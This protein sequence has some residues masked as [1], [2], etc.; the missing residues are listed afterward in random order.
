MSVRPSL[1]AAQLHAPGPEDLA[2]VGGELD[3][4]YEPAAAEVQLLDVLAVAQ[5]HRVGLHVL[6]DVV[7]VG[8]PRHVRAAVRPDQ[9]QPTEDTPLIKLPVSEMDKNGVNTFPPPT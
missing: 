9:L 7:I 8:L 3:L 2:E 5:R 6:G 4:L 1:L